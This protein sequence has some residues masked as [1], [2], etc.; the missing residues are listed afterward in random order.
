MFYKQIHD[1]SALDYSGNFN[2]TTYDTLRASVWIAVVQVPLS[3]VTSR[4]FLPFL[5]LHRQTMDAPHI[6]VMLV[7]LSFLTTSDAVLPGNP[8]VIDMTYTFDDTTIYWPT[9]K[10]FRLTNVFRNYTAGGYWYEAAEMEAAD[11]GGT[12]LDA[13]AHFSRNKWRTDDIPIERLMGPAVVVDISAKTTGNAEYEVTPQDFQDWENTHGRIPDGCLLFVK[14]GWG[15]YWPDKRQYLGTD[16]KNTSLL[17]FP[18]IHPDGARWLVQNRGMHA[19][20]IDTASLDYGQSTTYESHQILFGANVPGFE[21]VAHLDQLPTKGAIVYALP[22]KIGDGSGGPVRMIGVLGGTVGAAG[23]AK[24]MVG[25]MCF[26]AGLFFTLLPVALLFLTTSDAVLPGNP[27][28]IDMT[29][30]FDGTTIYWPTLKSFRLTNVFRNYTTGGFWFESSELE[31][32][33]H[34][35]TH[36]DAPAHF[37]RNNWRTDDIPI[38]RLMGPAVVV[39]ISAKTTGNAEYMVTAQDFQDW[40]NTHGRIPDGCLLFVKTGWGKY[41]PDKSQYLGTDT[42]NTSLLHFPGIHPDG[43]RWLVQNRGMHAVGIDTASLDYGQST[44]FEVHQILFG[45][46]VPGFENVAHLDQLPTK[47]AIVY[48]L[49]MKIGDGSGGPLRMIGVLGGTVGAAGTAK[50]MVGLMCFLAG[51]FFTLLP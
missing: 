25:L 13:P 26:L 7:A 30:T 43:A 29:Y 5:G 47:G 1:R 8:K 41:W 19:V 46:N 39:D 17:H 9:A 40:E 49:P 45:A 33:E 2:R 32:A 27:K 16:T 50:P 42:K 18:G 20:G 48:A 14:T 34:G 31:A 6:G 51:L 11:H 12:H 22:M 3:S 10:S 37:S 28:V 15:K 44:T 4:L 35:G 36:L 24:P 23:T 38:E 21:N